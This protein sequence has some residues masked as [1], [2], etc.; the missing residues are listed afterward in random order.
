MNRRSFMSAFGA[1]FGIGVTCH[2]KSTDNTQPR[3]TYN[4][5]FCVEVYSPHSKG[6]RS[7]P[8]F[9]NIVQANNQALARMNLL[10]KDV[11]GGKILITK[12]NGTVVQSLTWGH[13]WSQTISH[14]DCDNLHQ[15][16]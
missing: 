11:P 9:D 16:V 12:P 5:P 2:S 4:G 15:L 1:L 14:V 10:K 13:G 8:I 3:E 6:D 7:L